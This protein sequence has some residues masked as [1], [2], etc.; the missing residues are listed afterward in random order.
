MTNIRARHTSRFAVLLG[1]IAC[2]FVRSLTA[3]G[4]HAARSTAGIESRRAQLSSLFEEEWQYELRTHPEMATAVGDN[5]YNDRLSDHSPQFHQSDLEA[6]RTF[7]DRFQAIDPAGLSAQ[8]TL[9]RELM[10]RNLRQDIEGAPFKS[11]EMP[12]NQ[13][14]G[15]HLELIDLVSLTPFKNLQDYENYLARLHQTPRVLEQLTGN[16]R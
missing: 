10:I 15:A 16:M 5:R 1:I 4:L 8:D 14:G 12:V 9:S 3:Q 7:L 2:V 13:M 11:W 6:K